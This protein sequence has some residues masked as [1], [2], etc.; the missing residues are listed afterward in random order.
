[1]VSRMVVVISAPL[2][3][4]LGLGYQFKNLMAVFTNISTSFE[5]PTLNELS[6]NPNGLS[7]FNTST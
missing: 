6:N 3:G 4:G 1:M 5:M 7:D 2:N